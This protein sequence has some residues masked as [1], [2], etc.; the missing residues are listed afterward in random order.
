MSSRKTLD[1]DL[2][3]LRKVYPVG[4][5]NRPQ[6]AN[7][8]FTVNSA[9]EGVWVNPIDNL[10]ANGINPPLPTQ[11][12]T[13]QTDIA[14][15][16]G[17]VFGGIDPHDEFVTK[18]EFMSTLVSPLPSTVLAS[19][20]VIA[21][22]DPSSNMLGI[23]SKSGL[24][25]QNSGFNYWVATGGSEP[26]K[27]ILT[28]TD[29]A[30]FT[31][32][33]GTDFNTAPSGIT[34]QCYTITTNGSIW[35]AG[36]TSNNIG[37]VKPILV[38]YNGITWSGPTWTGVAM[39]SACYT[40][41]YNGS[42]WVAVGGAGSS[43]PIYY[44]M[45]GVTWSPSSGSTASSPYA[46]IKALDYANGQWY[47]IGDDRYL[48]TSGNGTQWSKS[49]NI[50]SII[51]NTTYALRVYYIPSNSG[52]YGNTGTTIALIG[53]SQALYTFDV[54][55]EQIISTPIPNFS[56]QSVDTNGL[57]WVAVGS[58]VANS[59]LYFKYKWCKW[60]DCSYRAFIHNWH[61]R[62]MDRF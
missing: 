55:S 9:G 29:F 31:G 15:L 12:S 32:Q 4:P 39:Q 58:G 25:V 26:L 33:S 37:S 41:K 60:L 24:S 18:T 10:V 61:I 53:N 1:I 6:P 22:P 20:G 23:V 48:Y 17:A 35:V 50:I 62:F 34:P 11:L 43:N 51:S 52:L 42:I 38:S 44:S 45:D 56:C 59:I 54:E 8:V 28:T 5:N 47:A 30:T 7:T 3:T 36:G 40:I 49:N 57:M 13:M 16:N 14:T 27:E 46:T 2:L 19:K 21:G